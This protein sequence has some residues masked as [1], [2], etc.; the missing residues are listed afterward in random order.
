MRV[1]VVDCD[2]PQQS[3]LKQRGRDSTVVRTSPAFERLTSALTAAGHE[4]YPVI[5]ST[6][7]RGIEHWEMFS[8]S[9]GSAFDVVFFDL[10]GTAATG[11]VLTTLTRMDYLIVPMKAD[12]MVLDSTLNFATTINDRLIKTGACGI[13]D[14]FLFWNMVAR[15][16]RNRLFG[17][18]ETGINQI[19]LHLLA[20]TIPMRAGF[21]RDVSPGS[22]VYR[23]TLLP[24]D[25]AF[26]RESGF[27]ALMD[28]IFRFIPL[29]GY[30]PAE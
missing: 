27:E 15:R 6:A 24:P 22:P 2:Y 3:I 8:R 25:R 1:A 23:C 19:G 7:A 13:R 9:D 12:R 14:M 16:E 5:G 4:P 21:G 30:A 29:S 10:P 17:I 11:G 28:E 18:Y 26:A 20:A